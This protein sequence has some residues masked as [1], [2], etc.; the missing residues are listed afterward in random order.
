MI[1]LELCIGHGDCKRIEFK[2][3]F[4][5]ITFVDELDRFDCIW[6]VG[7]DANKGEV[8]I[9]ESLITIINNISSGVFDLDNHSLF[10]QEYE[11]YEDAYR[12]ALMI[13]EVNEKCYQTIK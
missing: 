4:E 7:A 5:L 2:S 9:T 12:V 6:L 13:R 10:I 11:T 8:I 3:K 1:K